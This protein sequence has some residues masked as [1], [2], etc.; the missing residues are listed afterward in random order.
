MSVFSVNRADRHPS[1]ADPAGLSVL[2]RGF[3]VIGTVESDGT[4]KIEGHLDGDVHVGR[5]LLVA[6]GGVVLGNIH[7]DEVVVAG[8]VEGDIMAT[9]RIVL[10]PGCD[11]RGDLTGPVVAVQEGG[12]VNGRLRATRV[13]TELPASEE[14]RKSA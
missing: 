11:V 14:L 5:Q 9:A 10:Q 12:I 13:E 7:A 6:A 2:A 3:R 1:D 8:R 4:V